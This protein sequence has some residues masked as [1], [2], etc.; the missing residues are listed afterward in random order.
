MATDSSILRTSNTVITAFGVL[1]QF[2]GSIDSSYTIQRETT[3]NYKRN[4][5]ASLNP[6][7]KPTVRYFGIGI[8][9]FVNTDDANSSVPYI[10][11]PNNL[12]LYT[13]IPFRCIPVADDASFAAERGAKGYRLR[14]RETINGQQYYCYY[15]KKIEFVESSPAF[16]VVDG[17]DHE[18]PYVI[19][20]ASNLNPVPSVPTD[21]SIIN[22]TTNRVI[23][24]MTGKL[25]VLG[26][27]VTEAI[28]IKYGN[29]QRAMISE[30]GLYTGE[31]R[32]L[33]PAANG[34]DVQYTEAIY[35]QLASHSCWRGF[36]FSDSSLSL[37]D[38]RTFENGSAIML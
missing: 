32:L 13:P 14:V 36:D 27:E 3:I 26:T 17:D 23:V 12:D 35:A 6:T 33:T 29:L 24:S 30:I 28:N 9:G 34:S 8:N 11:S 31:E 16:S 38:Y 37:I 1:N 10:P 21:T 19:D 15:L 25:T 20:A 5:F 4:C 18:I 2:Y 7:T 22:A